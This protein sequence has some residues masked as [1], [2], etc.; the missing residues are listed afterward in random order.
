MADSGAVPQPPV[1]C[2]P[3]RLCVGTSCRWHNV[4]ITPDGTRYTGSRSY[5]MGSSQSCQPSRWPA[6][7]H[8]II[9]IRNELLRKAAHRFAFYVIGFGARVSS[10]LAV[11]AHALLNNIGFQM[12]AH[13]C[14]FEDIAEPHCLFQPTSAC[15]LNATLVCSEKPR[16]PLAPDDPMGNCVRKPGTS[17]IQSGWTSQLLGPKSQTRMCQILTGAATACETGQQWAIPKAPATGHLLAWRALAQLVLRLQ[18]EIE[19]RIDARLAALF[20]WARRDAVYGAVHIRRRDKTAVEWWGREARATPAC[21]YADRLAWLAAADAPQGAMPVFV[22]T[23]DLRALAEFKRCDATLRH[24]WSVHGW[25]EG[26]PA[27]GANTSVVLRLLSEMR[28][29]VGATWGVGTFTSNVGRIVQLLRTQPPAS[30]W[31]ADTAQRKAIPPDRRF[32]FGL[33]STDKVELREQRRRSVQ[34]RKA[35]RAKGGGRGSP[36][37]RRPWDGVLKGHDE[38]PT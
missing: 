30:F 37:A 15:G 11:A 25:P 8:T 17:G 16:L 28:L 36:T 19:Q 13:A 18:P 14:G 38:G 1:I 6:C 34:R 12:S 7:N 27:R 32:V 23:D 20:P 2:A 29:L 33:N 31:S 35:S 9:P 21:T 24:G 4:G 10:M 5:A 3:P 22:A 26:E